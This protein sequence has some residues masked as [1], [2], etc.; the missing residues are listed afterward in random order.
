[1]PAEDVKGSPEPVMTGAAVAAKPLTP[2][3]VCSTGNN[4]AVPDKRTGHRTRRPAAGC[5]EHVKVTGQPNRRL[6]PAIDREGQSSASAP[7]RTPSSIEVWLAE[8]PEFSPVARRLDRLRTT[9]LRTALTFG[10]VAQRSLKRYD[11]DLNPAKLAEVLT[12][13][14][15]R[16][17]SRETINNRRD[18]FRMYRLWKRQCGGQPPHLEMTKLARA[19]GAN[20]GQFDDATKIELCRRAAEQGLT[21]P[22]MK[23]EVHRLSMERSRT[24]LKYDITPTIQHVMCM[25]GVDLLRQ[26]DPESVDVV[27][28]DWMYKAHRWGDQQL[29]EVHLPDDPAGH[30][31][32][33]LRAAR[34]ALAPHGAVA[35]FVDLHSDP[36]DRIAPALREYGLTKTDQHVWDKPAA[37]FS[38]KTGAVFAATHE[39][40]DIYRRADVASFPGHLQY[41]PSV[42]PKWHA[43]SHR[44]TSERG[45]HPF[46]KPVDLMKKLISAVTVNGLVV[47][48]F[49][50]SGSAGVAAVELGCGYRGA[51]LVPEYVEIANRRIA[52]SAD[53]EQESVQAINAALTGA[54]ARQRAA[55]TVHLE[56]AGIKLTE[57]EDA[58]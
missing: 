15:G 18:A 35:L 44:A 8:H 32:E 4:G 10:A 52:L 58:A 16:K 54:T 27:I 13:V 47:D 19:W 29:P 6:D 20:K 56:K 46:E 53:R 36:D 57:L 11:R 48:V 42:S 17:Y 41:A 3:A 21:K 24:Q 40:T 45:V 37:T 30:L 55:I 51:E 7:G 34:E 9:E 38:G 1:M 49:A 28:L 26:C 12:T 39:L 22:Q 23:D 31:I 50:G 33:C 25:D 2:A 43:R 14:T 5:T